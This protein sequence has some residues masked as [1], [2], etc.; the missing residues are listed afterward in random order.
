MGPSWDGLEGSR[1]GTTLEGAG[2]V[3]GRRKGKR[4]VRQDVLGWGVWGSPGVVLGRRKVADERRHESVKKPKQS[5][6]N[7]FRRT[8]ALD[9]FGGSGGVLWPSCGRLGVTWGRPEHETWEEHDP[10]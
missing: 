10:M 7:V 1:L 5:P 3:V 9:H 6:R 2:A 8:L 4:G